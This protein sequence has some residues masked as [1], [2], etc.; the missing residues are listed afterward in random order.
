MIH[1]RTMRNTAWALACLLCMHGTVVL[2]PLCLCCDAKADVRENVSCCGSADCVSAC[3][4][5]RGGT[6][7]SQQRCCQR[8]EQ[9]LAEAIVRCDCQADG[10][11]PCRAPGEW[12]IR[13]HIETVAKAPAFLL[14]TDVGRPHD[15]AFDWARIAQRKPPSVQV[16]FCVWL[17]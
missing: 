11:Q 6:D 14:S 16:L 9:P 5:A 8:N 10:P 3:C 13:Q 1:P 12:D 4:A 7:A 2:A 17:A 15:A